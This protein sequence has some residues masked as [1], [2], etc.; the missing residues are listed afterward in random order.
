MADLT[1]TTRQLSP[2][3][4][5]HLSWRRGLSAKLVLITV[6]FL[7][8]GELLVFLPSV[9]RQRVVLINER[10]VAGHV[11]ALSQAAIRPIDAETERLLLRTAEILAVSIDTDDQTLALGSMPEI[12]ETFFIDPASPWELLRD[13]LLLYWPREPRRIKIICASPMDPAVMVTLVIEERPLRDAVLAFGLRI[14]ALS[15]VLSLFVAVPVFVVLRWLI[16]RPLVRIADSVQAFRARPEDP[17]IEADMRPRGDEIGVVQHALRQTQRAI[18]TALVQQRHL[19]TIGSNV[20]RLH[21]DLR[22]IL[23]TALLISER[24]ER[25]SEPHVREAAGDL[26]DTIERATQLCSSTLDYT[27]LDGPA[28]RR[29]PHNLHAIAAEVLYRA[30]LGHE[31]RIRGDN[32]I[33][34]ALEVEVD[35]EQLFRLLFN[36]AHNAV[37]AMTEHGGGTLTLRAEATQGRIAVSVEDD[38][39]G[40]PAHMRERLFEPFTSGEERTGRGLGLAIARDIARAHDGELLFDRNREKGARFVV[41]LP[42]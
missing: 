27:R 40:I 36:L 21:H 8:L 18:R 35:R 37:R 28:L 25:S 1:P 42:R 3:T 22:N 39:P 7:L 15:L 17:V 12:A 31:G 38:G 11:A 13:A 9:A 5:R 32:R 16:V 10:L 29:A 41:V 19:A 14:V 30:R 23:A 33:D 6:L 24:L 2:P 26:M 4:A 34:P 20:S